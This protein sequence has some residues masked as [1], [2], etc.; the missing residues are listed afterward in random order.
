MVGVGSI[1]CVLNG[2]SD[3]VSNK[4]V[5]GEPSLESEEGEEKEEEG[6]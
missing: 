1:G 3:I 6:R 4:G 5:G 2:S